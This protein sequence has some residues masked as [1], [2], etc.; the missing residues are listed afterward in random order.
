MHM[1]EVDLKKRR[2]L[3]VAGAWGTLGV[4]GAAWPFLQSLAPNRSTRLKGLPVSLDVSSMGEGEQK[5]VL[6]RGKPVWVIKR[7]KQDVEA[8]KSPQY[9]LRD[10]DSDDPQQPQYAKNYYRSIDPNYLVLLGVCTHLGCAPTY[11]PEKGAIDKDW[12][13]GFFCSCHGS[14]F[15]LAGR[16]FSGVPAPTNLEVPPYHIK[17]GKL[18]VGEDGE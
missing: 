18:V 9:T 15:D 12:P 1:S 16:V 6:W 14:K 10:P 11:R 5:T 13:G 4:L 3:Q 8:L 7:S 17:D 2:L